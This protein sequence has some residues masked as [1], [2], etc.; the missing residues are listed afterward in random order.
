[1]TTLYLKIVAHAVRWQFVVGLG[2]YPLAPSIQLST[3]WLTFEIAFY[4]FEFAFYVFEFA[5]NI[6]EFGL[7]IF[8]FGLSIFLIWCLSF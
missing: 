6:F 8:E 1:M 2:R 3:Y 7:S 4:L 5:L